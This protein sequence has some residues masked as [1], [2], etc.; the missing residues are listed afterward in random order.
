M[1]EDHQPV[2]RPSGERGAMTSDRAG[3][4]SRAEVLRKWAD[5]DNNPLYDYDTVPDAL[6]ADAISVAT[7]ALAL[8]DRIEQLEER[9][10]RAH[11]LAAGA[12]DRRSFERQKA[13]ADI[14]EL[15]EAT[16]PLAARKALS[17]E[18]P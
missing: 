5:D 14:Q 13:P 18:K 9:M 15:V 1:N 6:I 2:G 4:R 8:L 12:R 16:A 10:R 17:G 3:L 11:M 7:E